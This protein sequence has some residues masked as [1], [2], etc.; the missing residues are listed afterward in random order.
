MAALRPAILPLRRAERGDSAASGADERRRDLPLLQQRDDTIDRVP[1]CDATEVEL[2]AGRVE[3][4]G[5]RGAIQPHVCAADETARRGELGLRGDAACSAEEAPR[6]HQRA[7][8]DIESAV[9]VAA[10]LHRRG[11]EVEQLPIDFDRMLRRLAIDARQRAVGFV[12]AHQ[13][14]EAI[15]FVERFVEDARQCARS[16]P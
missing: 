5:Q 12:V 7:D 13:P 8:G 3:G 2:Y 14:I 6:L 10:V 16:G 1:F 4:N 11:E 9:R 15:D